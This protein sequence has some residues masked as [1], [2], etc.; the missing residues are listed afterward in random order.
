L[1]ERAAQ[2]IASARTLR[3][4]AARYQRAAEARKRIRTDGAAPARI[5]VPEFPRTGAA[6]RRRT[7]AMPPVQRYVAIG[8]SGSAGLRDIVALLGALR[9]PLPAVIMVV[10]HRPVDLASHLREV[11]ARATPKIVRI[12]QHREA[13][14]ANVVY[15]GEPA[16][17]LTML[18]TL[19]AGL[20]DQRDAARQNTIDLLFQSLARHAGTRAV[21]I[22]LAGSFNDGSRGLAAIRDARG[23]TM[24]VTPDHTRAPGMPEHATDHDEPTDVTGSTT[25]I[26]AELSQLF[27]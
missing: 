24:V 11:L 8:A 10:L 2:A 7:R 26:A 18:R 15:I 3:D 5:F 6:E 4:D 17:H 27:R 16:R 22:V 19:R 20:V 12:A 21:G 13:L 23:V 14:R 9:Q 1:L 25:R